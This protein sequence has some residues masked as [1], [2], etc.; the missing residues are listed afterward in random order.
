MRG[1]PKAWKPQT[2]L[3]KML[4]QPVYHGRVAA[5]DEDSRCGSLLVA[6]PRRDLALDGLGDVAA[7]Q[8]ADVLG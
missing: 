6:L 7:D 1:A 5:P 3:R 8:P 4:I 2:A